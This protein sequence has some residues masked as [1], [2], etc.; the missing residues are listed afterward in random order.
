MSSE[1]LQIQA[2]LAALLDKAHADARV[3]AEMAR[4][5]R[6]FFGSDQPAYVDPADR[7]GMDVAAQRFAEWFLVERPSEVLGG[8]PV[9]ILGHAE[10]DEALSQSRC[11]LFLVESADESE[12][13]VRDLEG[14][15]RLGLVGVPLDLGPGDVLVGRVYPTPKGSY[16]PSA[17]LTVL[18]RSPQ[19]AVAFQRDL[20]QLG[21]D[22]RLM[23]IEVEHLVFQRWAVGGISGDDDRAPLE[24]IEADLQKLLEDAGVGDVHPAAGISQSLRDAGEHPGAVIGPL[25]DELAFHTAVDLDRLRELLLQ[26]SNAHR[27]S[28]ASRRAEA[29]PANPPKPKAVPRPAKPADAPAGEGLGAR[30]ARR[31]DEGLAASEDVDAL[32]RDV[33]RLLGESL[34]DDE[35]EEDGSGPDPEV[36]DLEPLVREFLWEAGEP[37]EAEILDELVQLQ[38]AAPVPRLSIEYLDADDYLRF[39]LQTWLAHPPEQ[40][41]AATQAAFTAVERFVDW[42]RTTQDVDLR[43]RLAVSREVLVARLTDLHDASV[44]LSGGAPTGHEDAAGI[45]RVLFCTDG[46]VELECESGRIR[47][48]VLQKVTGLGEGDLILGT[49]A[50]PSAESGHFVGDA[51]ALPRAVEHLLG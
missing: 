10:E 13:Q 30:L 48:P 8:T 49:L 33:E 21:L 40:R 43:E 29:A 24:H 12:V 28:V 50:R 31:L 22:R 26:L 11:G 2:R 6:E 19:I 34:D 23:Q 17:V 47:I 16:A 42:L 38:R 37:A 20:R 1:P 41:V 46:G 9:A 5:R 27:A 14:G 36:G 45:A 25:M 18:S 39:V 32:F 7:T 51:V 4:A 3:R 44:A 15:E 35:E